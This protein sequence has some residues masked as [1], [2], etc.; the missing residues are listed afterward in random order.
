MEVAYNQTTKVNVN[1]NY[2]TQ[3]TKN[4]VVTAQISS[5]TDRVTD[6]FEIRPLKIYTLNTLSE[7]TNAVTELVIRNNA[8]YTQYFSWIFDTG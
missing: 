3:G 7:G 8:N 1:H 2:T 5:F 4:V 6:K